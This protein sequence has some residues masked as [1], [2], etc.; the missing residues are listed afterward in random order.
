MPP[1]LTDYGLTVDN[2]VLTQAAVPAGCYDV[3]GGQSDP[4][5]INGFQRFWIKEANKPTPDFKSDLGYRGY[6]QNL[7]VTG[8]VRNF[9][10]EV[11]YAL[12]T[13][14]ILLGLKETNWVANQESYKPDGAFRNGNRYTYIPGDPAG[15]RIHLVDDNV[16]GRFVT[17]PHEAMSMVARPRSKAVGAK[18]G[19]GGSIDAGLN[20]ET[21]TNAE[22]DSV[23]TRSSDDHG[24][25]VTRS[26]QEVWPYYTEL[27]RTLGIIPLP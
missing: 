21:F 23:F 7:N 13:G 18:T 9:Y 11:D 24:A 20:L 6:L 17:D 22:G 3:S 8:N 12:A 16:L 27:G 1:A 19:V 5:S 2:Y 4:N 26:I 15:Q 25:Q 10:N 14:T